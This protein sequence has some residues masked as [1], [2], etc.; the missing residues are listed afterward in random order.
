MAG[1]GY[2]CSN[3]P[4]L[5]FAIPEKDSEVSIEVQWPRGLTQNITVALPQRELLLVEPSDDN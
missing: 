3:E 5:T 2:Q 1:S 4:I